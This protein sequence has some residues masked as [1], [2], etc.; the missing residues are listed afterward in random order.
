M[1]CQPPLIAPG[2]LIQAT[3]ISS[4]GS[5]IA[6]MA[7]RA[8]AKDGVSSNAAVPIACWSAC[9]TRLTMVL[10]D[11]AP[12]LRLVAILTSFYSSRPNEVGEARI[13]WVTLKHW[14]TGH[15]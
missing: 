7:A 4:V 10:I 9:A 8:R 1:P 12:P 2:A 13:G 5:R 6:A 11:L 3:I 15:G 14:R